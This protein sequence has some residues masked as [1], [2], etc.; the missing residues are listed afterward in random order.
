[1]LFVVINN[2]VFYRKPTPTTEALG[3][4]VVEVDKLI[5]DVVPSQIVNHRLTPANRFPRSM[6]P[7][8][9]CFGFR[10]NAHS[11]R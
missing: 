3:R 6:W 9:A 4:I 11:L 7:H 2:A 8:V 1:M 5:G 10:S